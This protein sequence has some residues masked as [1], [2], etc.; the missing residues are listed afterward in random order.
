MPRTAAEVEIWICPRLWAPTIKT[1]RGAKANKKSMYR[2]NADRHR[3]PQASGE[4]GW[5]KPPT[6][7]L[8]L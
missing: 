7:S 5:L 1:R 4:R 2:M 8:E 3:F 6:L